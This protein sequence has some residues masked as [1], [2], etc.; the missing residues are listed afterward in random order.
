ML[1]DAKHLI[2]E[3]DN[4][5]ADA[6]SRPVTTYNIDNIKRT[7][8]HRIRTGF[9]LVFKKFRAELSNL[10]RLNV[11]ISNRYLS[12]TELLMDLDWSDVTEIPELEQMVLGI[13]H[14]IAVHSSSVHSSSK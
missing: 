14:A 3:I 6:F 9:S 4:K 11:N 1:V 10:F 5:M 7:L 2:H 12:G 13:F 8:E